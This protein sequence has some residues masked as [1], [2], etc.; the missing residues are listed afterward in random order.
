MGVYSS[1]SVDNDFTLDG[2]NGV[3]DDGD[4]ASGELLEG[5]LG[6]DVDTRE[7][8]AESRMRVVP[9]DNFFWPTWHLSVPTHHITSASPVIQ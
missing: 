4:G 1:E 7:P 3:N 2:L 6:I 5:L 9:S 8:T